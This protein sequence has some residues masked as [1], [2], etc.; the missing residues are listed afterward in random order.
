MGRSNKAF[1]GGYK[2]SHGITY[3]IQDLGTHIDAHA[4]DQEGNF[5]SAKFN[6]EPDT[7]AHEVVPGTLNLHPDHVALGVG[8]TMRN[9]VNARY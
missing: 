4:M 3:D 8:R 1:R 5:S 7:G 9:L 2:D 6:F